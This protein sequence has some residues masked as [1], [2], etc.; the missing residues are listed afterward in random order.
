MRVSVYAVSE[1]HPPQASSITSLLDG[2]AA[3]H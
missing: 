2:I 3:S 1:V